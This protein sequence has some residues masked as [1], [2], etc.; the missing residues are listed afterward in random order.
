MDV[1]IKM[2]KSL[3]ESIKAWDIRVDA[4]VVFLSAAEDTWNK[5]VEFV[6]T[7][8]EEKRVSIIT[9][10]IEIGAL[11]EKKRKHLEDINARLKK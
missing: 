6:N 5:V 10:D 1:H 7:W 3:H 9:T 2:G 4:L 11:N 8:V